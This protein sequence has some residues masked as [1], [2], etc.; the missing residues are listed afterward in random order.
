[1]VSAKQR[2]SMTAKQESGLKQQTI[3]FTESLPMDELST[4]FMAT[5]DSKFSSVGKAI[6]Y[7]KVQRSS[8]GAAMDETTGVFMVPEDGKYRFVFIAL[9]T[10]INTV[11]NLRHNEN[12]V[13][14]S[15]SFLTARQDSVD[16]GIL[17]VASTVN[18]KKGDKVD[19]HLQEGEIKTV[20]SFS[21]FK[22]P[23]QAS[24]SSA[25]T[26]APQD[27]NDSSEDRMRSRS[28][29]PAAR[30]AQPKVPT[31]RTFAG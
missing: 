22:M 19:V 25:T 24:A 11:V 13:L 27:V 3:S 9:P 17:V 12:R 23:T 28:S 6:T 10:N 31:R 15:S 2:N 18:L 16:G 29:S 26:Q 1:M 21:G 7:E 30:R 14:A 4:Y 20:T 5:R 8:M